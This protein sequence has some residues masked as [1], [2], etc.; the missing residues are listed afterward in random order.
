MLEDPKLSR[1]KVRVP[2]RDN[3]EKRP[4]LSATIQ[5]AMVLSPTTNSSQS[6]NQHKHYSQLDIRQVWSRFLSQPSFYLLRILTF[7]VFRSNV[8]KK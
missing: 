6:D 5:R 3:Y 4:V 8:L 1:N 2:R 7:F